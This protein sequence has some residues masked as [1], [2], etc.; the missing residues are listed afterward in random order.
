M[1]P[2]SALFRFSFYLSRACFGICLFTL[3]FY[4]FAD[5]EDRRIQ[6]NQSVE[7]RKQQQEHNIVGSENIAYGSAS[8]EG[9]D[10]FMSLM[11][12]VNA[13]DEA[14]TARLLAVYQ[15]QPD[16]DPDMVIFVKANQAVFRNDMK[17]AVALYRQVYERNP[18]FVRGK[19][20][21]ARLLFI[22]KQNRE[23]AALF[24]DISVPE[25][26]EINRK[27][28]VFKD[29]LANREA[30]HGSVS[31][32]AGYETNLNRS[33][34]S[35]VWREQT[36][37]GFGSDG[38]PILD[39]NG[40][41]SC[42]TEKLPAYS[43]NAVDGKVWIYET[44]ANKRI[45]LKGHHGIQLNAFALGRLYPN[46]A[47]Y[48][49]HNTGLNPTY[50]FTN[51]NNTFTIGPLWQ[52][53]WEGG[54]LQSSNMGISTSFNREVSPNAF[55]GIQA[56]H[57]YDRYRGQNLRHFNGPQT[58]LFANGVYA[59]PNNWTIFGGYDYLRKNSREAVDSYRRHGVRFGINKH[60]GSG[61]DT[62]LHT[63]WR[64]T[65]YQDYHAWLE[66]R[67]KDRERIYQLDVKFNRPSLRG[68]TPIFSFKH[69][70]N[71]SSSW[72]NR[73][74]RNEFVFKT[75]YSF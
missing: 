53:N 62:T 5:R 59:L 35:T 57:K 69:T 2:T 36:L 19:L 61:I 44:A 55:L 56:E 71:R 3:P 73:Y 15:Q 21:L 26:P 47:E 40:E 68:F 72:V 70:D 45:S 14:E 16:Y 65:A 39:S 17:E 54:R 48:S 30:W 49:E 50:S 22:D 41:L 43:P 67:R 38:Q 8:S 74:K 33:S 6:L 28:T 42:R 13:Q 51:K 1:K 29:A 23:A 46:H 7:S 11:Q 37:C 75:E 63:I 25:V 34:E 10:I 52:H 64:R 32:G 66:T 31:L 12:A 24:S 18:G 27:I 58:L 4:S 9:E 20:D 60:F